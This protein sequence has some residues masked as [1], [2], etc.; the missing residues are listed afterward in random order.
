MWKW[1]RRIYQ[2]EATDGTEGGA[3]GGAA[4]TGTGGNV[5]VDA[6][7]NAGTAAQPDRTNGET[8]T[9]GPEQKLEN[10]MFAAIKGGLAGEAVADD[11]ADPADKKPDAGAK[12]VV[13]DPAAKLAAE[14]E[15]KRKAEEEAKPK[16]VADLELTDLEKR[17]LTPVGRERFQKL[18]T[19]AK[20]HEA[21]IEKLT[22]D[23]GQV[24]EARDGFLSMLKEHQCEPADLSGYLEFNKLVKTG[25]FEGALKTLDEY[26]AS[27]YKAI[28]R[29][30]PGIDLLADFPDLKTRVDNQEIAREDAL[31]LAKTRR[32][33]AARTQA[34]EQQRGQQTQQQAAQQA[35]ERE[36]TAID[37]WTAA[38]AK[39]DID[40]KAKEAKLL[41]QIS[42]IIKTY[43]PNLWL[44]TLKTV[45]NAIQSAPATRT[46]ADPV[47][48]STKVAPGNAAATDMVSA[49]R[50]AGVGQRAA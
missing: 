9:K 28:G 44:T 31:A 14:S 10:E 12:P 25:N 13:D 33:D 27:L 21:T 18:I 16:K 5:Q 24:I 34:S 8:G 20:E 6:G 42:E 45:Y 35:Q 19:I 47:V 49:L 36:L 4:D 11:K 43:P 26:R 30:A 50:N 29:E 39:S 23:H 41:P 1:Q 32:D 38:I 2:E 17:S 7:G 40:Y 48:R 37:Q 15:V 3:G 46:G 22:A